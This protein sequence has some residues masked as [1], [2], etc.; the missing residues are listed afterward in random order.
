MSLGRENSRPSFEN[1]IIIMDIERAIM[2][3]FTQW[4][5]GIQWDIFLFFFLAVVISF[6]F[7][8]ENLLIE[9]HTKRLHTYI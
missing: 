1:G 5:W 7:I 3:K 4:Q 8:I 6:A 2:V 9:T